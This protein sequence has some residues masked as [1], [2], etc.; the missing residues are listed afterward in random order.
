MS[1]TFKISHLKRQAE[2]SIQA[3]S[4]GTAVKVVVGLDGYDYNNYTRVHRWRDT[5]GLNVHIAMNGPLQLTF[6]ELDEFTD[7]LRAMVAEAREELR[8]L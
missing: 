5:K 6:D 3:G 2:G 8:K 1:Y 7:E 4:N